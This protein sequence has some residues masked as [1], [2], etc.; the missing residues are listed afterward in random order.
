M[1]A[2][3]DTE[4][5]RLSSIRHLTFSKRRA[6]LVWYISFVPPSNRQSSRS[7][8]MHRA[9]LG[10]CRLFDSAGFT[11]VCRSWTGSAGIPSIGCAG[12]RTPRRPC[13]R[14]VSQVGVKG[15]R[16]ATVVEWQGRGDCGIRDA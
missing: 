12:A 10:L 9:G 1:Q 15:R 5:E 8:A 3:R 11:R 13:Q 6:P 4:D 2:I 16:P 14:I 7:R